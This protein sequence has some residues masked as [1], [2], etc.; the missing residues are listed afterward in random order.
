MMGNATYKVS[1]KSVH[2]FR[3]RKFL[4]GFYHIWSWWPSWSCDPHVANKLTFP[5]PIHGGSTRNLTL[6]G[7]AVSEEKIY[8]SVNRRATDDD[9]DGYI[10]SSSGEPAA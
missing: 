8:E 2:L 1:W 5:I 10:V 6:I 3:S 9:S 7:L 4:K